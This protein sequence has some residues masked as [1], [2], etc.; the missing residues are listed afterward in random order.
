V[1]VRL[2]DPELDHLGA[3]VVPVAAQAGLRVDAHDEVVD[4]LGAVRRRA[5]PQHVEVVGDRLVVA[6][7]GEVAQLE[8]H[9][10]PVR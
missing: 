3:E 8:V 2:G 10:R 7:L 4:A 6:V 1:V 9:G 5:H